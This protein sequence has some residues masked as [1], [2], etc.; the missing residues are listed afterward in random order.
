MICQ[1]LGDEDPKE[2]G[3]KKIREVQ[4]LTETNST[5]QEKGDSTLSNVTEIIED[6][7]WKNGV[8]KK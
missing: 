2:I 4:E 8:G 3:E 7:N 1:H 6:E 5:F